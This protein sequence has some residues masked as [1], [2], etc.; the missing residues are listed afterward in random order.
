M[1]DEEKEPKVTSPPEST[2]PPQP[3]YAM[4]ISEYHEG[5]KIVIRFNNQGFASNLELF[6]WIKERLPN[7]ETIIQMIKQTSVG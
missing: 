6:G 5:D 7:A 1:T 2:T 3:K 4:F